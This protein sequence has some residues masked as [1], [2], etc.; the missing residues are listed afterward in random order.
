[1]SKKLGRGGERVYFLPTPHLLPLL[2]IVRILSQF[3]SLRLLSFW[4]RM[5]HRLEKKNCNALVLKLNTSESVFGNQK[6][7]RFEMI[8]SLVMTLLLY[9]PV[10]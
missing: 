7:G 2:L 3:R 6:Q 5:L 9:G 4:K 1:M 10:Y 8:L